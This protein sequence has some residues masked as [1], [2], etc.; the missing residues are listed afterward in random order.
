MN[1]KSNFSSAGFTL[2]ESIVGIA[3][4]ALF[5][6]GIYGAFSLAARVVE[7]SRML[8]SSAALAN[9][10]F[11]IAHNLPYAQV[12]IVNGI[13]SGKLLHEQ[14]ITRD[15]FNFLVVTSVRNIDDPFDGTLGGTPSDT[16]PDDYKLMEV[17]ISVPSDPRFV[18]QTYAEYIAP[19]NL[20]NS[21]TNGALFVNV[22]DA[23]GN[24]VEAANVHVENDATNPPTVVDDTTDNKGILEIVDVPP[25]VN[26]YKIMVS[27]NGYSQDRTYPVGS[28]TNPNPVTPDATVAIQQVT[29]T[30][31]VI[32]QTSVLNVD[33]VTETCVPVLNIAFALQGSKLIGTNPDVLKFQNNFS[34]GATGSISLTGLEW[35][36]YTLT[37]TDTVHDLAG[38]ISPIPLSLAPGSTQDVKIVAT[39]KDPDSLL[40]SVQQGGTNL[41]LSG[42]TVVL[43][44]GTST[45]Q[46]ITGRGFLRQSDW[47]GGSGQENFTSQTAYESSDGNIETGDPAGEIKLKNSFGYYA[48]SGNLTSST[49]DTG[50]ASN[51]Y[52]L[53]FSPTDQPAVTGTSSVLLQIATNN[54]DSTWNFSGPDGTASTFYTATNTDISSINDGNRY[55]RYKIYLN[56]AS[57]TYTP[58]V[59]EVDFTFSSLCVP[60]G[61]VLFSGLTPGDYTLDV[62]EAGFQTSDDQISVSAPW[63]QQQITLMPQ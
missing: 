57:S 53:E 19:K 1:I 8:V 10:E 12:G 7:A 26:A 16:S 4:L 18:T 2:I 31:F 20:E 52:Q 24:A 58:D 5:A 41:P 21:T 54:D 9:E 48:A 55:F 42:A 38:S 33:S 43:S 23:N 17:D 36:T 35:D 63:Q 28:S 39:D 27:K 44:Q 40:V 29:Q 50:S 13:P 47:S 11:E 60:S 6:V 25:G 15:N 3:I 34:T 45:E 37:F 30:S 32:D 14:N 56:T 51:F 22:F 59:G 46:L 49:F 62:S 61:Q